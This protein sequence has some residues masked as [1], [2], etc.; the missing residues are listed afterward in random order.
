MVLDATI[1]IKH[2]WRRELTDLR[3][4]NFCKDM[5]FSDMHRFIIQ[6]GKRLSESEICV[7]VSCKNLYEKK[8]K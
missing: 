7:C 2:Y 6:V 3:E 8:N 4:C 5:I 1:K